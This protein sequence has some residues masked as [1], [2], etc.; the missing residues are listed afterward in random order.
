L[1]F[2]L[3]DLIAQ[4]GEPMKKET[5]ISPAT[6]DFER[7]DIFLRIKGRLPNQPDDALTQEILD[8]YCKKYEAGELTAGVVPLQYMYNLIKDGKINPT[9]TEP[10]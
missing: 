2:E 10:L 3:A 9:R 1:I 6:Y 7:V 8:E 5:R 4:Q